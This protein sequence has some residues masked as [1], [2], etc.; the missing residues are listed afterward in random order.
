MFLNWVLFFH[1]RTYHKHYN[2][3]ATHYKV[4]LILFTLESQVFFLPHIP[5]A[6]VCI[7]RS[8]GHFVKR[9]GYAE[10][11]PVDAEFTDLLRAVKKCNS[12]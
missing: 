12:P 3:I 5:E 8:K 11:I 1:R 7:F 10:S 2:I 4:R 9:I 6:Q